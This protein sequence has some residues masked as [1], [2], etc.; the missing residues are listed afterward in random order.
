[1]NKTE[2]QTIG[3]SASDTAL[4][5]LAAVVAL[6]GVVGFS[7]WSQL[8]MIA[9]VGILVGGLGVGLGIAWFTQPG[10]RLVAFTQEAYD[11]AR[12]VTWPSG[13]ETLQTTWIVFLFVAVMSLLLFAVDKIIEWGLYD[14]L[15]GWKR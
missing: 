5:A 3:S 1:M 12:R 14:L 6:A 2:V 11:E 15:L 13:K 8:P 10:K 7:F 9:R 4:V